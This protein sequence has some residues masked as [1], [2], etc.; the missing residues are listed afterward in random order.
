MS[1]AEYAI[2]TKGAMMAKRYHH[3]KRSHKKA[4]HHHKKAM[5]YAKMAEHHRSKASMH[6]EEGMEKHLRGPVKHDM[7][8][9]HH[10]VS[11]HDR[12]VDRH[13]LMMARNHKMASSHHSH[14]R[15]KFNDSRRHEQDFPAGDVNF[16]PNL[17]MR[18]NMNE[19]YAG[20]P[21]KKRQ[22]IEDA[23]MIHE[24]QNAIANLPQYVKIAP[25]PMSYKYLP[26]GLDDT[27]RGVDSQI[28]YDDDQRSDHFYPKKV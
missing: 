6:E 25:Y 11:P 24:D 10:D 5:H 17:A 21:A 19:Y 18:A 28:D 26:E 13:N 8:H 3:S 16:N 12:A 15:N 14:N 22:E 20:M 1:A 2:S 9:E 27:I 7:M 23:S 4:D